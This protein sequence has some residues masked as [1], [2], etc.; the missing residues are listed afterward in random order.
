[1]PQIQRNRK[2]YE[3]ELLQEEKKKKAPAFER[4]RRSRR[5]AYA[6]SHSRGYADL[7]S[8]GRSIRRRPAARGIFQESI[9]EVPQT[10]AE[11]IWRGWA[12]D[13]AKLAR[14]VVNIWRK[15][16]GVLGL[17]SFLS[18]ELLLEWSTW[19]LCTEQTAWLEFKGTSFF[20][21]FKSLRGR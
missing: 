20:V 16:Q 7:I 9:R 11:N 17:S 13:G 21:V 1:M 5:S 19:K 14:G 2:K 10:A 18:V 8:S 3:M 12:G 4:G 6:F 15:V